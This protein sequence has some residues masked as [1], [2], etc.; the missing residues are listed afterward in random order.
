MN[1][2]ARVACNLN[3]LIIVTEGLL[4]VADSHAHGKS[5]STPENV[6]DRD[7]LVIGH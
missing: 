3:C 6:Q 5:G 2:T 4:K 7:V 1:R